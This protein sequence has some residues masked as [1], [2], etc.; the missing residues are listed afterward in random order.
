MQIRLFGK[1][2]WKTSTEPQHK[3]AEWAPINA[4]GNFMSCNPC[5][6]S[7]AMKAG[8]KVKLFN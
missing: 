1:I 2:L 6:P 3:V 8:S 7:R 4:N 5:S